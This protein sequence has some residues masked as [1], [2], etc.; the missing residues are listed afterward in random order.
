MDF[1]E[2]REGGPWFGAIPESDLI[3]A[4]T[5]G[6]ETDS[7]LMTGGRSL[8]PQDIESTLVNALAFKR[9]DFKF[10]NLLK[11]KKTT[12]TVHE[13]TRR[14]EVGDESTIF[15]GEGEDSVE[16]EQELERVTRLIKYMQTYRKITLQMRA[17][18][19]LEDAEASEKEGGTLT[20]LKGCEWAL[21][22]GNSEAV[23]K[24][25]DGII[26]Q[27]LGASKKNVVD[28]RGKDMTTVD[29]ENAITEV[30][31]MVYDNGGSLTHSFM[32]SIIAEDVQ[33]LVRDRLRFNVQDRLGA[34]VVER[35]P[36]PFSDGILIAGRE[37]GPDKF[38]RVKGIPTPGKADIRPDAPSITVV[39]Q[40][41]TGGR[42]FTSA[43]AGTYYYVVYAISDKG[44]SAASVA[45]SVAVTDGQEVKI[46][47]TSGAKPGT[48][49]IIC[50]SKKDA[51]DGSDC[52]EAFRV[53]KAESGDT[54]ALD[55]DDFL[56]GTGEI[57]FITNDN[58]QPSVQWDQFLPLM[59]FDLY[60][61]NAAI[62]P[63][64]I[65]LFGALDVKVPWYHG[66]IKNVGYTGLDW[67]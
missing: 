35:Y 17:A 43:T 46:T 2:A 62:I 23:P 22:R 21:F 18:T 14:N 31:R 1:F 63:F 52:R 5:A 19:T 27:L 4:L 12:S 13:Y 49:F 54:I 7:A 55:Q 53:A 39:A 26:K 59:K 34:M 51:A 65:V 30:A 45:K 44:I 42:G 38:F 6:Y 29:G 33:R 15:V 66:V 8:I 41:K 40:A 36:T 47:I 16:T 57:V 37:G 24:Q 3:K 67:F 11:K 60:P 48:G 64:L 61:T 56:P 20:I 10:M 25:F 28:L 32:P 58:L 50:R 9:E